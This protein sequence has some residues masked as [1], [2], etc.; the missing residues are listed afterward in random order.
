MPYDVFHSIQQVALFNGENGLRDLNNEEKAGF[1]A[2][3]YCAVFF[4][5]FIASL[6]KLEGH[7]QLEI[8]CGEITRE[9]AKNRLGTDGRPQSFPKEYTRIWLS[10]I[11]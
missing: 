1:P 3:A 10:N 2:Y 4:E 7:I 5:A 8:V 11:P 9:L 6:K